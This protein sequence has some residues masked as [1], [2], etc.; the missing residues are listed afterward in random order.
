VERVVGSEVGTGEQ[1]VEK[2]S[3]TVRDSL[4]AKQVFGLPTEQCNKAAVGVDNGDGEPEQSIRG[5][6]GNQKKY[7]LLAQPINIGKTFCPTHSVDLGLSV[8]TI[9]HPNCPGSG[10]RG[11]ANAGCFG[12][13]LSRP[14][15]NP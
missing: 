4:P 5:G 10:R 12:T 3:C 14:L 11:S 15:P 9:P 7:D 13:V 2:M 1:K 8:K 6:E